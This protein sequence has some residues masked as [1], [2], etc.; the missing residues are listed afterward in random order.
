M[1][2]HLLAV[3][4]CSA[5]P[6][7]EHVPSGLGL[8]VCWGGVG[9]FV[10][11]SFLQKLGI[12]WHFGKSSG[13]RS[14]ARG[15][16]KGLSSSQRCGHQIVVSWGIQVPVVSE[17]TDTLPLPPSRPGS[18]AQG[19]REWRAA[20]IALVGADSSCLMLTLSCAHLSQEG[21]HAT[22]SHLRVMRWMMDG[23]TCAF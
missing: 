19:V 15:L 1:C 3:H 12:T 16:R 6:R 7:P 10:I 4:V 23:E 20:S 13:I 18:L 11:V 5:Q 2:R 17:Q 21:L 14:A 8:C 9:G 22:S